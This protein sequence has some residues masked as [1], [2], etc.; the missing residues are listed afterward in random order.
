MARLDPPSV[1][2]SD[3]EQQPSLPELRFGVR[4]SAL[5]LVLAYALIFP[6]KWAGLMPDHDSWLGLALAPA[7]MFGLLGSMFAGL[8]WLRGRWWLLFVPVALLSLAVLLELNLA[9]WGW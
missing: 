6:L 9:R 2:R 5:G 7:A 1:P 8:L 4:A 3:G